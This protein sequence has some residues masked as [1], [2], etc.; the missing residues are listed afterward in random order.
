[1]TINDIRHA[2]IECRQRLAQPPDSA[3]QTIDWVEH[4]LTEILQHY[5]AAIQTVREKARQ[6]KEEE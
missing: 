6:D 1:M 4:R 2:L 5:D 3:A